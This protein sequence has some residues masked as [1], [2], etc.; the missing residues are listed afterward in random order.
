MENFIYTLVQLVHN[1]GAVAVAG[2]PV[3]A[4]WFGRENKIAL[5][6]LTWLMALGWVAQGASGI[7]FAVTSYTMKGALPEVEGV[8]LTAL[9]LKVGWYLMGVVLSGFYFISSS[10]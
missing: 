6:K 8:E 7:G 9:A 2:S 1:F 10:R 4:L 5:H 3:V